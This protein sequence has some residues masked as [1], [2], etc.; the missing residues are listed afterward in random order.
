MPPGQTGVPD[1]IDPS[2]RFEG[3]IASGTPVC[4]GGIAGA[5]TRTAA[6]M[7]PAVVPARGPAARGGGRSYS[8]SVGEPGAGV[9]IAAGRADAG[10][11]SRGRG[12]G[13]DSDAPGAQPRTSPTQPAPPQPVA[14]GRRQ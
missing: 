4:P 8:S 6:L 10:A 12:A 9:P 14:A 1:A 11:P 3:S 2:R 13:N 7:P 5:P